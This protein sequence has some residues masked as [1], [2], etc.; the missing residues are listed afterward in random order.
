MFIFSTF[1]VG[2]RGFDEETKNWVIALKELFKTD[3]VS[4]SVIKK[5]ML[6]EL[7]NENKV[8]CPAGLQVLYRSHGL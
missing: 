1:W 6:E 8:M 2:P 7:F 3:L 4:S 5:G